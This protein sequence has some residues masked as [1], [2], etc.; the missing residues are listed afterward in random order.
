MKLISIVLKHDFTTPFT[1]LGMVISLWFYNETVVHV[2]QGKSERLHTCI[3]VTGQYH[4]VHVVTIYNTLDYSRSIL[5]N[6]ITGNHV[7]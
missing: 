4:N 2:W 7:S 5:S 1:Q 6:Q 3:G